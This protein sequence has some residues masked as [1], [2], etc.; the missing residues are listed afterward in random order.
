MKNMTKNKVTKSNDGKTAA[1]VGLGLGML[2][3]LS[4]GAYYLYGT[5]EG[6]KKRLKIRGWMLKAKGEMME[7]MENMK[8]VNEGNYNALVENVMKKYRGVKSI[9]PK[10]IDEMVGDLKK[11]WKNIKRHID[12]A[13]KPKAKRKT[14]AKK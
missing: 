13:G 4:A 14:A 8:E 5:K 12:S 3:A 6:V 9:D 10:E 1:E 11:H 7:K 2:A